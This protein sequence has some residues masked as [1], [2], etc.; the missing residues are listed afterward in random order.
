MSRILCAI[1][2]YVLSSCPESGRGVSSDMRQSWGRC[3]G[4]S[5]SCRIQCIASASPERPVREQPGR[6]VRPTARPSIMARRRLHG[7]SLQR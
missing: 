5:G 1:A 4:T 3:K 6:I 7:G 2:A